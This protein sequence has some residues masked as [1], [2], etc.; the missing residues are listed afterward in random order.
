M[1]LLMLILSLTMFI[2]G[3]MKPQ[4]SSMQGLMIIG[5]KTGLE[6]VSRKQIKGIFRGS[7][8]LWTTNEQVI[9]VMPSSK[10]DFAEDFASS[11]LQ[12]SQSAIHKYWLELV[13]QGRS[14]PPVFL[15]SSFEILEFVKSNP[16]AIGVVKMSEKE[17]PK[18][19]IIPISNH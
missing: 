9:V 7:Q 3:T 16:G 8:T 4:T 14:N 5:N 17:V 12:M 19:M 6:S 1:K 10:A 2:K 15:N 11:V 18:G 13:F